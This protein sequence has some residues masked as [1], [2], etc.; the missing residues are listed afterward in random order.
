MAL[1]PISLRNA[2]SDSDI[3]RFRLSP[4]QREIG[5]AIPQLPPRREYTSFGV[6]LLRD[7][8]ILGVLVG[9]G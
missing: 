1:E 5:A 2:G 9:V 7:L 6:T 4:E 8:A 3:S